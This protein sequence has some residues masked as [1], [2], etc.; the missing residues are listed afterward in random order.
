MGKS[1]VPAPYDEVPAA[2]GHVMRAADMAVPAGSGLDQ[3]PEIIAPDFDIFSLFADIF[4][5]GNKNAGGSAVFADNFCL[6]GHG[7]YNLVGIFFAVITV[8]AVSGG[9]ERVAHGR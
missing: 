3:F 6:V 7:S 9:N 2:D 5:T 8:R 1:A 4:D